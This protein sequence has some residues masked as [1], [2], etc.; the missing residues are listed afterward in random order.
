MS[1]RIARRLVG[2]A[3]TAL[4]SLVAITP[5]AQAQGRAAAVV[6]ER[7]ELR[8]ITDT[9]P[10]LGQIVATTESRVATRLAGIVLEVL[11]E[12]G[13]RVEAGQ[14]LVRLDR[15]LIEI[16]RRTA[17]A[18]LAASEAGTKVAEAQL[19]LAIQAFER[20]SQL[21]GSTAFSKGQFDDLQESA[22]QARSEL[23]RAEA[24]V[25]EA[26]AELA[27]ADYDLSHATIFAPFAGVVV[28]RQAQP[29]S[30]IDLGEAVA[31]L[32]DTDTLEIEMNLPSKLVPA[33]HEGLAVDVEFQAGQRV[34]AMVRSILPVEAV[35]TRTRPVRLSADLGDVDGMPLAAGKSATLQVPVSAPRRALTVPKDALVQG[36]GGWMVFSVEDGKATPR[37]LKLGRAIGERMEVLSGLLP[38]EAVVVRGNE[39][40]RPGQPVKARVIGENE[41]A[42]AQPPAQTPPSPPEP[43]A[44]SPVSE[45]PEVEAPVAAASGS[46]AIA[47]EPAPKGTP[48]AETSAP[49][50]GS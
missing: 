29:G 1:P 31:T 28:Q 21:Q 14:P 4:L 44:E 50:G 3:S 48:A 16:R 41:A 43:S 34:T 35:N 42:P 30:Y 36:R 46:V 26:E 20:T 9:T 49:A 19:R 15:D 17:A 40:L 37:P 47:A 18:S 5:I 38:G 10:I 8:E 25:A 32:L 24:E 33:I 6:A 13:D 27:R 23:S 2:L 22:E 11:F 45:T 7:A 12:V 39:R